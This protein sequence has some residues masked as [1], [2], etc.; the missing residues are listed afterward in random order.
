MALMSEAGWL[1]LLRW[2]HLIAGITWI[3]LLYYFNF[4]QVPFFAETGQ[5]GLHAIRVSQCC[6][7]T[8]TGCQPVVAQGGEVGVQSGA[9]GHASPPSNKASTS[10]SW[11]WRII[12][13][14]RSSALTGDGVFD[15][16][17]A[18]SKLVLKALG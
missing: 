13:C 6:R 2:I 17:K 4:V 7:E 15:T 3:G 14:C 1:F 5:L 18:V 9:R 12:H 10:R 11:F 8:S 16:L